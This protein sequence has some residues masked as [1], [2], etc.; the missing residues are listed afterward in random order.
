MWSDVVAK[1]L[2]TASILE[3]DGNVIL[4]AAMLGRQ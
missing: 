3:V 4:D 1:A 2:D